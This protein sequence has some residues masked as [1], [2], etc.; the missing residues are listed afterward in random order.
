MKEIS[1]Q[2]FVIEISPSGPF[3]VFDTMELVI[4]WQ[5]IAAVV[6]IISSRV[7]CILSQA[8]YCDMAGFSVA[9]SVA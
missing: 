6:I 9:C 1:C 3:V 5:S 7:D 8:V 2:W 4:N